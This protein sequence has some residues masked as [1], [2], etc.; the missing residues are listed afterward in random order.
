MYVYWKWKRNDT[1]C[2]DVYKRQDLVGGYVEE[3]ESFQDDQVAFLIGNEEFEGI[4]GTATVFRDM[5]KTT[6]AKTLFK[7][8]DEFFEDLAAVTLNEY[9]GGKVYYIGSGADNTCLLYTSPFLLH[10]F[11]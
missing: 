7:Y 5:L 10:L 6:T 2:K 11:G 8:E 3:V 1:R 9:E 4:N